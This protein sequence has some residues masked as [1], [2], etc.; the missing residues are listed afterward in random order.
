MEQV[1]K[2]SFAARV[3]QVVDENSVMVET[4]FGI[5]RVFLQG[6][7]KASSGE[8]LD[9]TKAFIEKEL[10]GTPIVLDVNPDE[11]ER[12]VAKAVKLDG[13]DA[14]FNAVVKDRVER[15]VIDTQQE[16]Q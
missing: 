14:D 7:P 1:V 11:R 9:A 3:L 2:L 4:P 15:E 13:Q 10:M 16:K 12:I 6:V 8:V 5:E